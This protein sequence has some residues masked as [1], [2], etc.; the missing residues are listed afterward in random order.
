[1]SEEAANIFGLGAGFGIFILFLGILWWV[2]CI[3]L[4][5][6][7]WGMTNDVSEI[8]GLLKEQLDLEHPYVENDESTKNKTA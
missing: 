6:K 5:F 8:K 3:V 7:I 1:M 2:L 4:F